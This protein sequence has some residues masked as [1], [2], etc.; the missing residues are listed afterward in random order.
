MQYSIN[1]TPHAL[2][3][4]LARGDVRHTL[5]FESEA[6]SHET[7]GPTLTQLQAAIAAAA[8]RLAN[9]APDLSRS[10]LT[11][12]A[13]TQVD[14]TIKP[15]FSMAVESAHKANTALE[16]ETARLFM[17]RFAERSEP[18]V[19]TAQ[20]TWWRA[21]SMPQKLAAVQSDSSLAAAVVEAGPALSGVPADIFERIRRDMA[22][23]QL[24]DNL[25]R[26]QDFRSDPTPDDPIGRK[27]DWEAARKVAA[28]RL[29]RLDNERELLG[30]IPALLS[31]VVNAVA[32]MTEES[33]AAAF[34]RLTA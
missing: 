16:A 11:K 22:I 21:L 25:A 31:S 3:L 17:P 27:P 2:V 15:A 7:V 10:G 23:G 14:R 5:A 13:G 8:E 28:A 29:D 6:T 33:R 32:L 12:E 4:Q 19:R 9:A 30:R 26:T 1:P 18:A 24:A 20:V 34:G